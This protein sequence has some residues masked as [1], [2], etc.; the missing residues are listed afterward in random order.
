MSKQSRATRKTT[1][2]SRRRF[3]VKGSQVVAGLAAASALSAMRQPA[4]HKPQKFP[5]LRNTKISQKVLVL[6]M[7]GM[8]PG[9]IRRFV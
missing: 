2:L 6:G 8:D 4:A 7:D 1:S 3:I 5:Y 9:L